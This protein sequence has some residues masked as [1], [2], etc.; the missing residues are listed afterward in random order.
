MID[1]SLHI[2]SVSELEKYLESSIETMNLTKH[3][4]RLNSNMTL[5][6]HDQLEKPVFQVSLFF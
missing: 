3:M 6:I 2:A 1:T 5:C 4:H